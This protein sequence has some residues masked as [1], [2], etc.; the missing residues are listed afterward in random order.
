MLS[1]SPTE[2]LTNT[3]TPVPQ[4]YQ[5]PADPI[6]TCN[7]TYP[8]CLGQSIQVRQSECPNITCCGFRN[9]TWRAE[10]K[11]QC[12]IDQNN[13][14]SG[15]QAGTQPINGSAGDGSGSINTYNSPSYPPCTIYYPASGTSQTF[16]TF[17]PETC[18]S[19]QDSAN[20][21]AQPAPNQQSI[22]ECKAN[23]KSLEMPNSYSL[24][25][26]TNKDALDQ[27]ELQCESSCH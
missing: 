22:D 26:E 7:S 25:D 12:V 11:N 10:L 16:T 20:L 9:G 3:P 6:I 5:A 8:S 1:P 2:T 23:C 13:D 14:S 15:S 17:S 19:F 18:K 21:S 27:Q 4:V 24:P